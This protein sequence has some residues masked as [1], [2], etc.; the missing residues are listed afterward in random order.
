MTDFWLSWL[1]LCSLFMFSVTLALMSPFPS[2]WPFL[3]GTLYMCFVLSIKDI[4][5]TDNITR[6]RR[7]RECVWSKWWSSLCQVSGSPQAK[8][9]TQGQ[10]ASRKSLCCTVTVMRVI[11]TTV[12]FFDPLHF[13]KWQTTFQTIIRSLM[14]C[15]RKPPTKWT[16]SNNNYK[17]SIP[18]VPLESIPSINRLIISF[19]PLECYVE[20]KETIQFLWGTKDWKICM[21]G[22]FTM[23][24]FLGFAGWWRKEGRT[25]TCER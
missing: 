17:N 11:C 8:Q 2:G 25:S 10:F 15:I 24:F 21:V 12:C 18:L 20:K 1:L 23:L 13:Y 5:V 7:N 19:M 4:Y 6:N 16:L 3:H 22:W 9:A 14:Y